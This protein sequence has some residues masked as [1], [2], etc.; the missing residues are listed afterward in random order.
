MLRFTERIPVRDNV[1]LGQ[2]P[3]SKPRGREQRIQNLPLSWQVR[4]K[5]AQAGLV[6]AAVIT[7]LSTRQGETRR[8]MLY[9]AYGVSK[10]RRKDFP[11]K[12]TDYD[13]IS[14]AGT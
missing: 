14:Q 7:S 1:G 10:T 12:M 9:P 6:R 4:C 11:L 8:S 3:V 5:I 2:Y 13:F